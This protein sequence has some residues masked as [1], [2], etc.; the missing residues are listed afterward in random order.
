MQ[1]DLDDFKNPCNDRFILSKGHAAPLLYAVWKQLG[2]ISDQ[3]LMQLRT[4][5]SNLEGHPASRFPYHEAATG[6]LGQGLSVGVGMAL[7]ARADQLP[8]KTYVLLGDGELAEGSNWEA[9]ELAH[10][11]KLENVVAIVDINRLGQTGETST[12][13]DLARYQQKFAAFG[14]R[15]LMV[16]GHDVNALANIF[17]EAENCD[18]QNPVPTVI[19]AQTY[20][21]F[22]LDQTIENQPGFHGK[23]LPKA[24]LSG[25]LQELTKRF[26]GFNEPLPEPV[27]LARTCTEQ[28]HATQNASTYCAIESGSESTGPFPVRALRQA[29]PCA[30]A[31]EDR[32]DE[33][34]EQDERAYQLGAPI[35]TRRAYGEAITILGAHNPRI[36]CLDGDVKNSTYS[37]LFEQAFPERFF[38]CFI[39]EQ[40][41][42]GMA[43]GL[44]LRGKIP[45]VSTFAAFLTRACD[46]I[47][48]A[49]VGRVPLRLVGSHAGVSIGE[50]GP[51]Q[52]GLEDVAFLRTIPESIIFY[53]CDATSTH[54]CVALMSEHHT[55]VSYLRTTRAATPVIYPNETEFK[56]GGCQVL[57]QSPNDIACVIAAGITVH[58]ALKA[59][60]QLC[61][62]NIFVRVIDCY[63]IKPL[64]EEALKKHA[65]ACQGSVITVEDHYR[66]GG[67]GEA[68]AAALI[69]DK[70]HMTS[71]A[72]DKLPRSGKPEEL[73]A[74]EAIDAEAI[75]RAVLESLRGYRA[76]T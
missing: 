39:A 11:Y 67:L 46:Q 33:R 40:N 2:K 17:T 30:K 34:G 9:A 74:Y 10:H 1:F 55:G 4:F 26:P 61:A 38:E 59:Y 53:P 7:A 28:Y 36:V 68:I 14:W 71:L 50:D 51:S 49:G 18:P 19:L 72:V 15:V 27:I 12:G 57:R 65:H 75:C 21:G 45:F 41:M 37:E 20:K 22:G 42:A 43:T 31:P 64:P 73:L 62:Q 25:I 29:S 58:E 35:A 69:N 16:D 54:A 8:Y 76:V 63:G 3:E 52:M 32:Q 23:A 66:A 5:D 56:I 24:G 48:M 60:D 6:S 44:A 70:I 47:R 13:H